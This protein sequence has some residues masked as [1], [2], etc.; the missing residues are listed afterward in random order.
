MKQFD[1]YVARLVWFRC[2]IFRGSRAEGVAYE[3]LCPSYIYAFHTCS[4][5]ITIHCV[6]HCVEKVHVGNAGDMGY[7][8]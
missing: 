5:H 6:R 2:V 4:V 7:C 3:W 8:S 1:E